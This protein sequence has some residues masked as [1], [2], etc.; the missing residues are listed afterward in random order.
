M[1]KKSADRFTP[2]LTSLLRSNDSHEEGG[3]E[4][5][6]APTP[7]GGRGLSEKETNVF[8]NS[9]FSGK[10]GFLIQ[11]RITAEGELMTDGLADARQ[12]VQETMLEES[13]LEASGLEAAPAI[14]GFNWISIGPRNI[15]GRIKCLAIHPRDG[16]ILY[17]GAAN[18]GVWK[19]TNRGQSWQPTM[20]DEE[21]LAIGSIAIDPRN[22]EVIYAGTGEPVY[23]LTSNGPLPPGSARLAW[24]Y[25]GVGVYRSTN[26]GD[27][28]TL[29]GP[30]EN[31]F[32]YRVAVDPFDSNHL[33]CAGFS[34]TANQGGLC[35]STDGGNSWTTVEQGVFTDVVFSPSQAGV[36]Y[37][38]Q[39]N[40]GIL[41]TTN[42]GA[43]WTLRNQ[44][45]PAPSRMGRISLTIANANPNIV[46]AKIEN[47]QN[48]RLLGLFR[49]TTGAEAPL[50]WLS[51]ADP[52][53][54]NNFIWWASYI[55]ADPAD[56]SGNRVCAGGLN[57]ALSEDGGQ[58]WNLAT[59]A[60]DGT[61]PA[62]HADQ[63]ALVFDPEDRNMLYIANDGGVFRGTFTG[64]T[65]PVKWEKASYGL[66][67]TQFYDLHTSP[68]VP[69]MVGGGAQ[70]NGSLISTGGLSWRNVYGGDG[71]YVAFHP[72][73]PHTV[74]VQSQNANIVRS[75]DGGNFFLPAKIGI[76]GSGVFP[77]TVFAIDPQ[78]P[79]VLFAGT[80]RIYRT[81]NGGVHPFI[82]FPAWSPASD[83]M[84]PV[85][86]IVV[87]PGASSIIYAGTISGDLYR[88]E[89]GG[90]TSSSFAK[91]TPTDPAWPRRWLAGIAVHPD[92]ANLLY[93]TFLGFNGSADNQSDHVW[94]GTFD[95]A[96]D[97][98]TWQMIVNGLPDVPVGAIA[99]EPQTQHLYI[100][101]DIGVF[102]SEDA[103]GSWQPFENGLP[104]VP[105]VD[106]A[107][108]AERRVLRA[109]THG[110][111][112]Y[113]VNLANPGAEVDLYIRDNLIDTGEGNESPS[114]LPNP[115]QPGN[116]V[117]H[118][119]SIDIKIDA[120]PLRPADEIV[121]GVEFD[122]P[123]HPYT[124]FGVKIEE[125]PGVQHN[126]P[127][128]GQVNRVYA[129]IHNRGWNQASDVTVKLLYAD[130][131]D[132]L[133]PLPTDFWSNFTDDTFDQTDWTLVG[134]QRVNNL[135]PATP[136]VVGWDWEVPVTASDLGCLLVLID[137]PE[138][139]L[140]P[141][142]TLDADKLT[143]S[144][145][146]V[147]QRL[148]Q[149]QNSP[150][151]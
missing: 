1:P 72:T 10:L 31:G 27:S 47:D 91:M 52:G 135:L 111:G 120:P 88:A 126:Q 141:E 138:D 59:D 64:S 145:K 94:Q 39:H 78:N 79:Q 101:T 42:K 85:T 25:E 107:L 69:S 54:D 130:I 117:D 90:A 58:S 29:T 12:Q 28:W 143:K 4:A 5:A 9:K 66:T 119:Q 98:W 116:V 84:G 19:T 109:A 65:P 125:I 97:A 6:P 92:N 51:V 3:L 134:T 11:R 18:G 151:S 50:G 30:M 100:A 48:G 93:V 15:N 150:I 17:A 95:S 144:N 102:R 23:L 127:F 68:V 62:T 122:D 73:N 44:G 99:V 149:A 7:T 147:A 76:K 75:T 36:A 71:G 87:S 16:R 140:H 34:S 56:P 14:S 26:G 110:R 2:P 37:A 74:Y 35:R 133:A 24:F 83:V 106:L 46:Y 61:R 81:T 128:R 148:I 57:V 115:I 77:A 43:Q 113:Q 67:I 146:R 40:G 124:G 96:T 80:D 105:V 114:D 86:E 104:N 53:V 136:Y 123:E 121:D 32:I 60:Y 49:T 33:L 70:D 55:S 45:L 103:G 112:M 89:D 118:H 38:A 63:H 132:G 21:S 139:P 137:S 108:D 13:A 129:Q 82:V 131:G 142:T 41:K 22:P 8:Q 20:H